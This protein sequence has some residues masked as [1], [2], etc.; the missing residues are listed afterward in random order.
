[1][2]ILSVRRG[3]EAD[4]SSSSYEFFALDKLTPDQRADVQRLTGESGRRH[5]RSRV[6][7]ADSEERLLPLVSQ[8]RVRFLIRTRVLYRFAF[9]LL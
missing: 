4:H 6:W 9:R 2:R 8:R 1:M 5:L 7:L 3:F